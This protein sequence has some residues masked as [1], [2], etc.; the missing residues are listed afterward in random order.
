MA[1]RYSFSLLNSLLSPPQPAGCV[2]ATPL[3]SPLSKNKL[4]H[5]LNSDFVGTKPKKAAYAVTGFKSN[6][7]AQTKI[8]WSHFCEEC[9]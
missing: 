8:L 6:Q 3:F 2:T 5:F 9:T 7:N 1:L 4:S